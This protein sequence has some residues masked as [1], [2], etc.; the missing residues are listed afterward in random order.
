M[1]SNQ[2]KR[3]NWVKNSLK[4]V[5]LENNEHDCDLFKK[6]WVKK[7]CRQIN[8]KIIYGRGISLI[9][10]RSYY[11]HEMLLAIAKY[12]HRYMRISYDNL[13]KT[14]IYF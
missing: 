8:G 13:K 4:K 1:Q 10:A 9:V 14:L 7:K 2:L 11:F 3:G 5:L 6:Q 12:E